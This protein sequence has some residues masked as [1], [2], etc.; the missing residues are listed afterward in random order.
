MVNSVLKPLQTI[1]TV[2]SVPPGAVVLLNGKPSG[3]TP[4]ALTLKAGG[5]VLGA[6]LP[7]FDPAT[8]QLVVT[9]REGNLSKQFVLK[10][11]VKKFA[12]HYFKEK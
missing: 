11:S 10:Q 3:K 6:Q 7:G 1:V 4:V 2:N 9:G 5:Y 12:F 8:Q